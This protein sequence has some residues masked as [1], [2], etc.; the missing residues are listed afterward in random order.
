MH[1][2]YVAVLLAAPVTS[3][4]QR[5]SDDGTCGGRK[6]YT[7]LGSSMIDYIVWISRAKVYSQVTVVVVVSMVG[8]YV[9]LGVEIDD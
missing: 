6:G 5:M 2:S 8:E 3:L 4:A 7:C 9:S 1:F